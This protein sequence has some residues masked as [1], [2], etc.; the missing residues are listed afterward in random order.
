MFNNISIESLTRDNDHTQISYWKVK[1]LVLSIE[2]MQPTWTC[3]RMRNE[4]EFALWSNKFGNVVT[5][6]KLKRFGPNIF[7]LAS[8]WTHTK[9]LWPLV[10]WEKSK[11]ITMHIKKEFVVLIGFH[12]DDLIDRYTAL[13]DRS[14]YHFWINMPPNMG[15]DAKIIVI[16]IFVEMHMYLAIDLKFKER[17]ETEE[18]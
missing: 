18:K 4:R 8:I 1:F 15:C 3:S 14:L 7:H 10:W 11:I 16:Y 9:S 5:E 2:Q 12:N 6:M 13:V 17:H